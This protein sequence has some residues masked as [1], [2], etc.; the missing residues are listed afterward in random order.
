MEI[1]YVS[2]ELAPFVKVGGLADVA[3]ALPK[4]LRGLGHKVTLVLPRFPAFEEGG[5]LV[6][7]R[8][9][10]IKLPA[11][12]GGKPID[13]TV[14]D[15]RLASQVDLVLIDAPGL[16]DRPGVYGVR[17]E[18][19]A[20]N[21]MR[22]GVLSRAAAE[23][24]R[25]R[26]QAGNPYDV[27]VCNDWPSALVPTYLDE[28]RKREDIPALATTRTVLTIHNVAHQGIFPREALPD[29]GLG[30]DRFTMDGIEFYGKCNLLKQGI[31][32]ADA[33]TTV[34]PTYAREI[35]TDAAVDR[36]VPGHGLEGVLRARGTALLGIVNGVDY[37][38][39]NPATDP[40]LPARYD[41]EDATGKLRCRG[42]LLQELGLPVGTDGPVIASIGRL[43]PQ[44]GIDLVLAMLPKLL[45]ASDAIVVIAGE[46]D[47]AIAE[48]IDAVAAKS[49]GRV[50]F[51]RAASEPLVHRLYAGADIVLVPSRT[52][53]C[54]LVQLYAQRYGSLPVARATG[55][56][57]D[58]IVDCDSHLE[59]GTGFL[60]QNESADDLLAATERAIAA[61]A[62][63]AWPALLRR[64]M[65]LDRGWEG[66]ARRYEQLFRSL[67]SR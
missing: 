54:G 33:V 9:T 34:S 56:L 19:Y 39:W 3:A 59:T 41:A 63:K 50:V 61:R 32:A 2:T 57:V 44:K 24:A 65:R 45:R 49:H 42:A 27:I 30:W 10:P 53:P 58:T 17:G 51:K 31:L 15:G 28:I 5:L 14:F 62:H 36:K 40:A 7:R 37:S 66:P 8:L 23:L 52:E 60:F 18:D 4:A 46:G 22:F 12:P 55:G 6:A 29:L 1:L 16:F 13:V 35:Q 48:K 38:V 21:A 64:V 25:Q 67:Q 26:A 47:D 20:D 11:V 43:V